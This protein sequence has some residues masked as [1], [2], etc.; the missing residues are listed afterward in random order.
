MG[1]QGPS[2]KVLPN[3]QVVLQD[4]KYMLSGPA[5]RLLFTELVIII[6]CIN[7]L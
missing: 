4:L 5:K 3:L 7:S 1:I 2:F 6:L